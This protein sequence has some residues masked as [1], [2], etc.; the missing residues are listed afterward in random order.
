MDLKF[1]WEQAQAA[2]EKESELEA[3]VAVCFDYEREIARLREVES[4]LK[5]LLSCIETWVSSDGVYIADEHTKTAK[6]IKE[7]YDV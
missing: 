6:A 5:L 1:I 7:K 4:D 2:K 3:A